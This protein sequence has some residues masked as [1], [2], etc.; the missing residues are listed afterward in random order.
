M[1]TR[2]INDK[3]P[4]HSRGFSMVELM[5]AMVITLI[6]MAGV[7]QIF[8]SSKQSYVIQDTLGRMQENGRYAMEVLT[9]DLRRAGYWGGNADINAI[10]D[11]TP[12][13]A[14]NGNKIA[15]DDGSCTSAD[16]ARMLTYSIFGRDDNR[17]NYGCLPSDTTHVGDILVVRYAA[18]WVVGGITTPNYDNAQYYIRS[19]LFEGKMF[20]GQDQ[21]ANPVTG[22]AVRT[23]ELVSN[24]YFIHTSTN[25]DP[26]KCTGSDAIPSLYRIGLRSGA[27]VSDE[28]AYGV[29]QFQVQY[30]LDTNDDGTVDSYVDAPAA[31]DTTSWGQVIA[32][33]VWILVRS[34]CPET[35]YTNTNTYAIGNLNYTP[36]DRYRRQLFTSTV[37]LRN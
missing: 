35:G 36:S 7:S 28:I 26:N 19:S 22:A 25:S 14:S 37:T 30:G 34:E 23:A 20:R 9:T 4:R 21:A 31:S 33:R 17:T 11:N 13:G 1:D 16:W 32:A 3:L 15:T 2:N 12:A 27:L 10:E 24:G 6:L 8:L 5:V 18:P 29:D